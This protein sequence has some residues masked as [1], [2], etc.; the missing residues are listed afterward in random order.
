MNT[1]R[2]GKIAK[3]PRDIREQ[4]NRRMDNAEGT[5]S[6]LEWLNGLPETRT[7]LAEEFDG[8]PISENNL[9]RWRRGGLR[10]WKAHQEALEK[11]ERVVEDA[12][13]I[14]GSNIG[15]LGDRL[16][17]WVMGRLILA[18][19]M[20][21][22]QGAAEKDWKLL[23]ELSHDVAELRKGDRGLRWVRL[24]EERLA[25][26]RKER[27]RKIEDERAAGERKLEEMFLKWAEN[28][29]IK[30]AMCRG[31]KTQAEKLALFREVLFADVDEYART[32]PQRPIPG[33]RQ[34]GDDDDDEDESKE[35]SGP[36]SGC[37]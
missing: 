36:V 19:D 26:Q 2:K 5:E 30:E 21:G 13:E 35:G 32:H 4:L 23:R 8:E 34:P 16:A 15:V 37:T 27:E 28:P 33:A 14:E 7:M 25:D 1:T 31:F 22:E 17:V 24:E 6:L 10:D 20:L 3:L 9:S 12:R 11:V 18:A 29:E